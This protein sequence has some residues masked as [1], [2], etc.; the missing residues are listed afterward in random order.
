MSKNISKYRKQ[1]L[2]ALASGQVNNELEY[3]YG[4]AGYGRIVWGTIITLSI[5]AICISVASG[6]GHRAW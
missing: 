2:K 1:H 5:I 6:S 3:R 4:T